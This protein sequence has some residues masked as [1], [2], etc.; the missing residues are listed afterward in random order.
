M[1]EASDSSKLRQEM[2]YTSDE[3][4]NLISLESRE[5]LHLTVSS[6]L[7]AA[8]IGMIVGK[9]GKYLVQWR[10]GKKLGGSRLDVSATTHVRQNESYETA[11]QRA[12]ENELRIKDRIPLK[13]LFDFRYQEELGDHKEN[14]FCK[15]YAGTYNGKYEPN[16][17]EIDTVEFMTVEELKGFV[18]SRSEKATKWLRETVKRM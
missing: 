4:G 2:I 11:I 15:V 10:S 7:H 8:V 18:L 12:F 3:K 14:E 13:H 6:K 5:V 16:P 1:Q 17:D 9:D